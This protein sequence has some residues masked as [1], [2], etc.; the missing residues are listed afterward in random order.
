MG[1]FTN[2]VVG[3]GTS[4]LPAALDY[5]NARAGYQQRAAAA[6]QDAGR[7]RQLHALDQ[8]SYA[9]VR[10]EADGMVADAKAEAERRLAFLDLETGAQRAAAKRWNDFTLTNAEREAELAEAQARAEAEAAQRR[11][12]SE[13][14]QADIEQRKAAE[15][16]AEAARLRAQDL[17]K[18][19]AAA[20]A[21]F[22]ASGLAASTSATAV[23]SG[24]AQEKAARDAAAGRTG[25]AAS[26]AAAEQAGQ[27]ARDIAS[28]WRS[29]E[30]TRQQN[31][32]DLSQMRRRA[33]LSLGDLAEAAQLDR[34]RAVSDNELAVYRA[35]NAANR[36]VADAWLQV[37]RS[38][39]QT[40][41]RLADLTVRRPDPMSFFQPV[42]S[43][44]I[45]GL[46]RRF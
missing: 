37:R 24:M 29:V 13:Q 14:Q 46:A 35:R 12:E 21:R 18:A 43:R 23:L 36:M 41:G 27:R 26:D 7:L 5:A 19:Q 45:S 16:R 33:T 30:S 34:S 42:V 3:V 1:G 28:L 11:L 31:L 38:A 17:K 44:T 22:G 4:L 10:H 25:Q 8:E 6:A 9:N 32:L 15:A 40:E 39:L 2:A 20:R